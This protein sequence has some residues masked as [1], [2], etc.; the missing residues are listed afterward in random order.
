MRR[1]HAHLEEVRAR[2]HFDEV[3]EPVRP[4]ALRQ[5]LDEVLERQ[6]HLGARGRRGVAVDDAEVERPATGDRD[7]TDGARAQQLCVRQLAVV[8]DDLGAEA[9]V[10][11]C[12]GPCR[13]ALAAG[14]PARGSARSTPW[15]SSL[16]ARPARRSASRTPSMT[17]RSSATSAHAEQV[18]QHEPRVRRALA[19]AAVHD[20]RCVVRTP[21]AAVERAQFVGRTGTCRPRSRRV[22]TGRCVRPG[23]G[24]RAEPSRSCPAARSPRR[25]TLRGCARPRTAW[26]RRPRRPPAPRCGMRAAPACGASAW[27][28]VARELRHGRR[29]GAALAEPLHAAAVHERR[30]FGGRRARAARARTRRTSCCCRRTAPR[31]C[32]WSMPGSGH[33]LLEVG[34]AR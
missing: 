23:R 7:A 12:R 30:P 22:P 1:G 33:Q 15:D 25:R 16:S 29:R 5:P 32:R 8:I 6:V 24:R 17:R 9:D 13:P 19:D 3:I 28:S 14:P 27:Y 18:L 31:A 20:D 21:A 34:A 2:R 26:P 11:A 10:E 4:L